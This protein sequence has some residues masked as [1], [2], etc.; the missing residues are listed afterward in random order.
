MYAGQQELG[1]A[2]GSFFEA[3]RIRAPPRHMPHMGLT[4]IYTYNYISAQNRSFNTVSRTRQ[5]DKNNISH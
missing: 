4:H 1:G 3:L 2:S 5:T